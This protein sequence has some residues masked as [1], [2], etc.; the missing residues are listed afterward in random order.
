MTRALLILMTVFTLS[1]NAPALADPPVYPV[2]PPGAVPQGQ[3]TSASGSITG[4]VQT[5][6]LNAPSSTVIFYITGS[7]AVDCNLDPNNTGVSGSNGT[8]PA[9]FGVML[10]LKVAI[11]QFKFQGVGSGGRYNVFAF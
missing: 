1:V 10:P 2:V 6:T 4:S 9:G 7:G 3:F 8:I 11:K 5:V